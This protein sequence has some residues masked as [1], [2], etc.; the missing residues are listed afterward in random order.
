[1]AALVRTRTIP[2]M[3]AAV[4][5][6]SFACSAAL[7]AD[8][9][10]VM[11]LHSFGPNFRPWSEYA[12]SIRTEL[13]RQS[14]W[15]LDITDHSLVA[16]RFADDDP[17]GPFIEY[18]GALFA[19]HPLDLIV[20]IGSPAASFVQRHRQ[21]L[22]ASTPMVFTAVEERRVQHS[23]LTAYDTVVAVKHD[24]PALIQNILRLLPDTKV[25]TVINGTSPLEQ[26]WLAEM[27]KEFKQ[28]EGR[29]NF[30]WT[31]NLSFEDILKR[32]AALPPHSAIFWELMIVDAAGSVHQGDKALA[33]L[34]EVANAP[35]FSFDDSFFGNELVGGPMHSVLEGGQ[36]TAE[37][38]IRILGGEKPGEIKTPPLGFSA[39]KYDWRQVQR[40]GISEKNLPQGSEIHFREPTIWQQYFWWLIL[41]MAVL[42]LQTALIAALVYE[43]R[44]RR[45]AEVQ[46]HQRMSELAHMNRHATMGELSTSLTHELGQP[47][48][49][50]L[51]NAETAEMMV[52]APSPDMNGIKEILADIRRDDQRAV[53]VIRHVRS[54]VKKMPGEVLNLDLNDVVREAF[55]FLSTQAVVRN[56][57][58]NNLPPSQP[59]SIR[60]DRIQLQQVIIN[61]IMN[62][63]DAMAGA[64]DGQRRIIGRTALLP[65]GFAEISISDFGPGISQDNLKK[66]F[67][68]FFTTK[69]DGMGMGLSIARTII[70]AHHGRIWAE[71][72]ASGGAVFRLVLPLTKSVHAAA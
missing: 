13:E 36:R 29:I 35:I 32:A 69:T 1:M 26:F 44:R 62:G 23:T 25:V 70:E 57:M 43:V 39:P 6:A 42:V 71:N 28:F 14:P 60:G 48:G 63:M 8:P 19:K 4:L 67:D 22:F 3:I 37:V 51:A 27:R 40:W 65:G 72:H 54:I 55:E 20:T 10:R 34:H 33:R 56:V 17:E 47:L 68:P 21:K 41:I 50:I 30:E 58:L 38:A 18:L 2:T 5:A 12:K 59:L 52:N 31:N 16:A 49:A 61:L 46:A 64:S 45:K 24:L 11:M 53:D 15:P 9:K 66:V 7:A